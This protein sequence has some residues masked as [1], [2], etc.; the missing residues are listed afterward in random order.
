MQPMIVPR[1]EWRS[2]GEDF[3]TAEATFAALTPE[4]VVESTEL[5]VLST[6]GV[7]VVKVRDDLMDVKHL[8][9]VDEHGLEQWTPVLKTAFPVSR[10][11]LQVVADAL[12]VDSPT[13]REAYPLDVLLEEVVGPDPR[14]R[15]VIV[16]KLRTRYRIDG[17]SAESTE[18]RVGGAVTRTV[19]V[20]SEDAAQVLAVVAELGLTG[21]PN[22]NYERGLAA[23]APYA[24]E[25][26]AVI[27]VGTNSVKFHLGERRDDHT[28]HTVV[29][30]SVVTRLGDGLRD[31]R[32]DLEILDRQEEARTE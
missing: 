26:Y 10:T 2:F 5:Y 31:V 25:R 13:A 16:H 7:D 28:W 23:L 8:R 27:D 9:E 14:L 32:R 24:A 4:Q 3:G 22:L 18:V 17:C 11:D 12:G 21:R 6:V 19:A 30:R 15:A 20:E 29:D 1:W